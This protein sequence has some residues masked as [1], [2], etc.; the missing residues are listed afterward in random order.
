MQ[1]RFTLFRRGAVYY[2]QDRNTGE[3]KSLRTRDEGEARTL[4]Q[5]KNNAAN[6]PLL[7]LT[8]ARTYLAAI[9]PKLVSRTWADVMERFC[10]CPHTATRMRHQRVVRTKPMQFLKNK[11]LIETTADDL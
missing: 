3:Q 1:N 2:S 6:L 4:I 7:N 9:D 10:S 5:T 8:M 11:R